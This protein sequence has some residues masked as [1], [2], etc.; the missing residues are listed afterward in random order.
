MEN[1]ARGLLCVV[2]VVVLASG[3]RARD[4][5]HPAAVGPLPRAQQASGQAPGMGP[6]VLQPTSPAEPESAS[7]GF[8]EL[9][10]L[11]NAAYRSRDFATALRHY[12]AAVRLSPDEAATWFG[13]YMA[14]QALGHV[15][16]ADSALP[17][18]QELAPEAALTGH[19]QAHMGSQ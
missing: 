15:A 11:G 14:H 7:D 12:D 3:C 8:R 18:A 4:A 16:A 13:V 2:A 6:P 10:A 1:A 19:A 9:L 17:R 5:Q